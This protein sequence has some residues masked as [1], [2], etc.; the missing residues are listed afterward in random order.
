MQWPLDSVTL[1][2]TVTCEWSKLATIAIWANWR[3]ILF[4]Q[5]PCPL[6]WPFRYSDIRKANSHCRK[7]LNFIKISN[8]YDIR[9]SETLRSYRSSK[10]PDWPKPLLLCMLFRLIKLDTHIE[11]ALNDL[12]ALSFVCNPTFSWA[13]MVDSPIF[14]WRCSENRLKMPRP[15][16]ETKLAR[17]RDSPRMYT[18][19]S[20]M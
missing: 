3:G 16:L 8:F 9:I 1:R 12:N 20:R 5:W 18:I 15:A 13:G 4:L 10:C 7:C 19:Q 14:S 11:P 6:Q 2:R 17:K